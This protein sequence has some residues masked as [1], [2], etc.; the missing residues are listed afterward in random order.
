MSEENSAITGSVN[1][2]VTSN[3]EIRDKLRSSHDDLGLALKCHLFVEEALTKYLVEV[4]I[5]M[6]LPANFKAVFILT[7]GSIRNFVYCAQPMQL[8]RVIY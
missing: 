4:T 2:Q 8:K 6:N 3:E 1:L 5:L 7:L